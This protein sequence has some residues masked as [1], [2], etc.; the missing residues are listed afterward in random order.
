MGGREW[1]GVDRQQV[2]EHYRARGYVVRENARLRGKSGTIHGVE[3]AVEGP[4]GALL[5]SFGDVAGVDHPEMAS[6][7][8]IARDVGAT[9]VVAA[10]S[11]PNDLRRLAPQL[12]VV[13]LDDEALAQPAPPSTAS[14]WPAAGGAKRE[15]DEF[16]AHPWPASG[17]YKPAEP[18][19]ARSQ[20]V[21]VDDLLV[22]L[23]APKPARAGEE[24]WP[25]KGGAEGG[26][27]S[28]AT[29]QVSTASAA[30]AA[31]A[32][33]FSW[34][35][36]PQAAPETAPAAESSDAGTETAAPR[37]RVSAVLPSARP[38]RWVLRTLLYALATAFFLWL[39]L[40]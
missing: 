11:F 19:G 1:S 33:P 2:A 23:D 8:R 40:R 34:L 24:L 35:G 30:P 39:F 18:A 12:G 32:A 26:P 9:P 6:I 16:E 7:R 25:L 37:H 14:P 17:R 27:V 15:P 22:H 28:A 5:V 10:A 20:A 38:R 4:L 21:E 36:A 31:Q 3:L 29:V 13:L